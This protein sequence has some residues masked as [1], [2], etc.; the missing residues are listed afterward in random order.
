MQKRKSLSLTKRV[1]LETIGTKTRE[2]QRCVKETEALTQPSICRRVRCGA[3]A[4]DELSVECTAGARGG[5]IMRDDDTV[6]GNNQELAVF[7]QA[8]F[9]L[10]A[11]SHLLAKSS[12]GCRMLLK[13]AQRPLPDSLPNDRAYEIERDRL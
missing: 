9:E 4:E 10:L 5:K 2:K 11:Q 13:R 12:S 3:K 7:K 6:A 1:H 8:A